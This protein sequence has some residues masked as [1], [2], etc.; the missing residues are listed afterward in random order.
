MYFRMTRLAQRHQVVEI[1]TAAARYGNDMVYLLNRI[2]PTLFQT[3]LAQWVSRCIPLSYLTP[4]SAVLFV[5]VGRADEFII[6][7]VHLL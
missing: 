4:C 6:A 1:I 3:N 7:A 2:E 5:A